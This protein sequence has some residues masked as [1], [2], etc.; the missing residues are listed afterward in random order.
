MKR[1]VY[2][3]LV[4]V[5]LLLVWQDDCIAQRKNKKKKNVPQ[6]ETKQST[7]KKES[8]YDR[9][10]KGKQV[11]TAKGLMTIHMVNARGRD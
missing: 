7:P 5:V 3:L 6:T 11:Q 8:D 4:S 2:M 1:I 9:L 10:F